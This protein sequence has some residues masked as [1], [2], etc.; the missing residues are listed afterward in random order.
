MK[1][2]KIKCEPFHTCFDCFKFNC[3]MRNGKII[4]TVN[5]EEIDIV[6]N[7][8]LNRIG[9][10]TLQQRKYYLEREKIEFLRKKLC[11]KIYKLKQK[12]KAK[13]MV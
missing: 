2:P 12:E 1:E 4:K 6:L 5:R 11:A 9:R 13:E 7:C 3:P 10:C 8:N